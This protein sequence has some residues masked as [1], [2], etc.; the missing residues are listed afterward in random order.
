ML[1]AFSIVVMHAPFLY[2]R[3][4]WTSI[5]LPFL[6]RP[7][8][9]VEGETVTSIRAFESMYLLLFDTLRL[10]P[11]KSIFSVNI[12]GQY[13]RGLAIQTY[14]RHVSFAIICF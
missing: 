13:F 8:L 12:F 14:I 4:G 7:T 6:Y 11:C 2:R 9:M 10:N 3:S 1:P 5:S